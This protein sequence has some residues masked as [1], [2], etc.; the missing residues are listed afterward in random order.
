MP[1]QISSVHTH[2]IQPHG[3]DRCA[4]C[5]NTNIFDENEPAQLR[6]HPIFGCYAFLIPANNHTI[7]TIFLMLKNLANKIMN[8]VTRQSAVSNLTNKVQKTIFLK[9]TYLKLLKKKIF[10]ILQKDV[11]LVQWNEKYKKSIIDPINHYPIF[12]C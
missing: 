1:Y 9:K 4:G 10:N 6:F 7:I 2:L 3:P 5:T 12:Y 8:F 11:I